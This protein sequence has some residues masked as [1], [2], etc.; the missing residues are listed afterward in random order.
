MVKQRSICNIA[1]R[2][3]SQL[4]FEG[5]GVRMTRGETGKGPT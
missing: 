1:D 5:A 2:V 4:D 3:L